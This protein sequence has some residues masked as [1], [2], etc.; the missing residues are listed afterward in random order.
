M[1]KIN[2]NTG[3]VFERIKVIWP[4]LGELFTCEDLYK[5]NEVNN[6]KISKVAT[7]NKINRQLEIG[8]VL[9]VD[10]IKTK[11]RPKNQYKLVKDINETKSDPLDVSSINVDSI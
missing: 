7:Q 9:L 3:L 11:G 4:P 5:L 10:S 1:S 2:K 6:V 8:N